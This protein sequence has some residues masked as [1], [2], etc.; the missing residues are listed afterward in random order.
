MAMKASV[1]EVA[2]YVL[3]IS[4]TEQC[5]KKYNK[6]AASKNVQKL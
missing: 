3:A 2:L 1:A 5:W 6:L 4:M